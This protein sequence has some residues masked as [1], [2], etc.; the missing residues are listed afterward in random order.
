MYYQIWIK[1]FIQVASSIFYLFKKNIPF[2]WGKKPIV[3][4]NLLKL[5]LITP[6][7]LVSLN[8]TDKAGNIILTMHASLEGWGGVLM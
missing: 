5:A 2:T 4:I 6:P 3:A 1:K 7:A 8:Y